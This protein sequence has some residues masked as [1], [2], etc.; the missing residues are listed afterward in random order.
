MLCQK[1]RAFQ[2]PIERVFTVCLE[3]LKGFQSSIQDDSLK[4][5]S[6]QAEGGKCKKHMN[7]KDNIKIC[8]K[9]SMT[10][11]CN[12]FKIMFAD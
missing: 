11:K 2:G 12:H 3:N 7:L 1:S 10:E 8:E 5:R 6:S 9:L 4:I